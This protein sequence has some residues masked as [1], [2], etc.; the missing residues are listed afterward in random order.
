[1]TRWCFLFAF[2]VVS[3][4]GQSSQNAVDPTRITKEA[5]Q[6]VLGASLG[7]SMPVSNLMPFSEWQR[8][9]SCSVPL[10]EV[11]IPKDTNFVITQV[12]PPGDFRDNMLVAHGLPACPTRASR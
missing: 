3:A 2:F 10:I 7:Q 12:P 1:M 9:N 8:E 6:A 4:F 5:V 11:R